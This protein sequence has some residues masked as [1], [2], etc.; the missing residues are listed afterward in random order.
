MFDSMAIDAG[1]VPAMKAAIE[2]YTVAV[3][4]HL[5]QINGDTITVEDGVYGGAQITMV[6]NYIKE[7][8]KQINTIVRY[9]NDFQAKLDEVEKAYDAKQA[10]TSLGTVEAAKEA[11]PSEMVTVNHME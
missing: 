9:F 7:T 8:C 4:E 10:A 11:D 1:Q 3:E 5:N 2:N 6:N